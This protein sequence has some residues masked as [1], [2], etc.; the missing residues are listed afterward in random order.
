MFERKARVA[1]QKFIQKLQ[2]MPAL[3]LELKSLSGPLFQRGNF[4]GTGFS[5]SLKKRGRG[6]F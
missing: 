6:D 3:K 1:S 4:L 5:P 2:T